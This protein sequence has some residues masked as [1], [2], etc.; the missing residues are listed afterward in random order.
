MNIMLDL[1]T[2]GTACNAAIVSIG[3]VVFDP[4]TGILSDEF[5]RVIDADDAQKYGVSDKDTMAWWMEQPENA[6]RIFDANNGAV[7]FEKALDDFAL[8]ITEMQLQHGGQVKIWSNGVGFDCVI[9]RNGYEASQLPC[10]WK[11]WNE[12]DV[13]TIVEIGRQKLGVNP[14]KDMLFEGTKHNALADAIHQARYVSAIWQ[15]F[16]SQSVCPIE[17][18]DIS[19]TKAGLVIDAITD[20]VT[21]ALAAGDDVKL[22][23]FGTF[24]VKSR[25]ERPGRNPKTGEA[26]TIPAARVPAFRAGKA[27]KE[28][29]RI[30]HRRCQSVI[31]DFSVTANGI[32]LAEWMPPNRAVRH[33]E[34]FLRFG[35]EIPPLKRLNLTTARTGVFSA[36][37]VAPCPAPRALSP[38]T[39]SR[40]PVLQLSRFLECTSAQSTPGLPRC[41]APPQ[42][43]VSPTPAAG[44]ALRQAV[45]CGSSRSGRFL[46][47]TKCG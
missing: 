39:P 14:K 35:C 30:R 45:R 8:W 25:A 10:P 2:L 16:G 13:R 31:A 9:L 17:K 3:A 7:E 37:V 12:F 47:R 34:R 32:T 15:E 21:Q 27:L 5:Y 33:H 1:E 42:I 29:V 11:F 24:E 22:S 19:Q 41:A 18:A 6:R 43:P 40:T 20:A 36:I 46:L 28:A 44:D 4:D 23:G 38:K 26:M